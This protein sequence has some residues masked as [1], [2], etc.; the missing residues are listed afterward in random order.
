M[1]NQEI[2]EMLADA[3]NEL[4]CK[5]SSMADGEEKDAIKEAHKHAREALVTFAKATGCHN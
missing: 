4:F 5:L 1:T 2:F 3:E